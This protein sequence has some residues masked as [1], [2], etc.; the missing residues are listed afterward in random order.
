M[1]RLLACLWNL[2][3]CIVAACPLVL[4]V[5]TPAY[6]YVDPSVMT[7]TVQAIAGVAVALSAILGV[8]IRRTRKVIFH[9]FRID[10]KSRKVMEEPVVAIDASSPEA[11]ALHAETEESA[12][13]AIA[14]LDHGPEAKKL[15]WRK[16]FMRAL[17]CCTFLVFTVFIMSP[18][19]IVAG[20]SDSLNFSFFDIAPHIIAA[21]IIAIL[22]STIVI[23]FLPGRV[24]DVITTLIVAFGICAYLQMLFL[25]IGLP[26]ADGLQLSLAE[27]QNMVRVSTGLWVVV[28]VGFLVLCAK[29]KQAC[30]AIILALSACLIL[31][32]GTGFVN[33]V[34]EEQQKAGEDEMALIQT[35]QGLYEVGSNENVIVFVLDFFDTQLFEEILAKHPDVLEEFTGFTYFRN[36]TGSMTPTRNGIPFLLTGSL[37]QDDDTYESFIAERYERSS[38]LDEIYEAGFDIGI[39]SDSVLSDKPAGLASNYLEAETY[40]INEL[41]LVEALEKA[42]LY[43]DLPWVLKPFFWFYT[44]QLNKISIA[45]TQNPYVMDDV[46]YAAKLRRDGLTVNDSEKSFRFIHL[47]GAHFP[48][49]MDSEGTAAEGSSDI[50]KQGRGAFAIVSDYLREL[51]C[52]GLY[53]SATIIVTSDHG[54]FYAVL[55]TIEKPTSP[56]LLAKPAE[57]AAQAGQP[58]KT[59]NIPTGHLDFHATVID[60]IGLDASAYGPTF[61]EIPRDNRARY[62]WM[63][64]HNGTDD[65]FWREFKIDGNVLDFRD[66]RLTG[67]NINIP[68]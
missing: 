50:Q 7:Y 53:D 20:S 11:A 17:L 15:G 65:L 64:G 16:R 14:F 37:P 21:G 42:A 8:A 6:A 35:A 43:R 2:F 41:A 40:E 4:L 23:A 44:D 55:D 56:I 13:Q 67:R 9:A 28:I 58:V 27:H 38:F 63:T 62:Y 34:L 22:A 68:N 57:T 45:H 24:F 32:Q 60:A 31:V 25:N 52:L 3:S 12:K 61:F 59:S 48:F 10:E 1:A 33:I 66:W 30:Q 49:V 26:V 51:K 5:T 29:K 54:D 19:E 18:L 46:A 36:S 39:Y 47:L